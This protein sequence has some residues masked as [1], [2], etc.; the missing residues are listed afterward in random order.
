L[1]IDLCSTGKRE[2]LALLLFE[3][4]RLKAL[5]IRVDWFTFVVEKQAIAIVR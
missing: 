2:Y 4:L 5:W 1:T 3:A